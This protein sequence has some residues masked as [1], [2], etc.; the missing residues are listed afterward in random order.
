RVWWERAKV[1]LEDAI[2]IGTRAGAPDIVM[3]AQATLAQVLAYGLGQWQE[4][5]VIAAQIPENFTYQAEYDTGDDQQ[6]NHV[7]YITNGD[8]WRDL[9][10]YGS[11]AEDL[12]RTTGDP[13]VRWE[14]TGRTD[15]PDGLVLYRQRKW[16]DLADDVNLASGREMILIR[17]EA[18]LR[19]GDWRGAVDLIN[20]LRSTVI[21]DLTGQPIPPVAA[22]SEVEAWTLLKNERRIE[23]W[24]EGR[25]MFDLRRWQ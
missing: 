6:Y 1:A 14:D 25:R 7:V 13:R 11:F 9:T 21:S 17:A 10:V 2:A 22:S 5:A 19:A 16:T 24:L 18:L 4:A 20:H 12:Y 8:P 23:L 15:T 3:N